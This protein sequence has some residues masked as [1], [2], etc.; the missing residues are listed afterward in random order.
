MDVRNLYGGA[1]QTLLPTSFLDVSDLRPIPDHQEV[2][3]DPSDDS[4][5]IV[6]L[7][8]LDTEHGDGGGA[9]R[10][11]F[12]ELASQNESHGTSLV[13]DHVFVYPM[14][15]ISSLDSS[16]SRYGVVG[17]QNIQKHRSANAP[18]D[19]VIIMMVLLR[20][21]QVS[22]DILITLNI[23]VPPQVLATQG[24]VLREAIQALTPAVMMAGSNVS[25]TH[26][27]LLQY[28]PQIQVLRAFLD[29]FR[30]VDWNLFR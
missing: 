16:V 3:L 18:V 6:E 26:A 28:L 11:Q 1:I 8:E 24:P 19:L 14:S 22:T 15:F 13:N 17:V 27:N 9:I 25:E 20:V 29:S 7:M 30:I 21:P 12:A 2:F 5:I 23:P 10:H 4:C